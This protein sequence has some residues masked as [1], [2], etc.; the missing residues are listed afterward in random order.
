MG[1][2]KQNSAGQAKRRQEI[3]DFIKENGPVKSGVICAALSLSRSSLS[4]DINA[5]NAQ[6]SV[7]TSPKRGYYAYDPEAES[8][9]PNGILRG[10]LD[11]VHIRQWYILALLCTAP[12]SFESLLEEL[13]SESLRCGESTLHADLKALQDKGFVTS[14]SEDGVYL[15]Y[16]YMLYPASREELSRYYSQKKKMD[17]G[18]RIL[19]STYNTIEKKIAHSIPDRTFDVKK[20]YA[21]HTGKQNTLSAV[22][23][24]LLEQFQRFPYTTHALSIPYVTNTGKHLT[25]SFS[26]GLIIYSVE[27]SRIYLLGKDKKK[28]NT[29]IALDRIQMD[30][31]EVQNS[32]NYCY[33]NPEF[34]RIE[35]EMFSLSV[36]EPVTVRVRFENVPFVASKIEHLHKMR[37]YSKLELINNDSE[38]LYTDTL[39]GVPDF[40]RYLRRFGHHALAE[41]PK[42]LKD[43]MLYTSRKVIDLYE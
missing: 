25:C 16:S 42:E 43:M 39:R 38:I 2:G 26:S 1:K 18:S 36:E 17:S 13:Q 33:K 41:E 29:I 31:I 15:Y 14:S 30:R 19:I 5:I 4:D 34:Y 32:H 37:K 12:R 22:Q 27:T 40:A 10:K 6:T 7:L 11:S 28:K 3:I 35:E 23:L 21:R 24:E 20:S 8:T 9:L